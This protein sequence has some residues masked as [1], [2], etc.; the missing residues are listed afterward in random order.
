MQEILIATGNKG[1]LAEYRQI[2]AELPL[3]LLSLHDVGLADMDVDETADNFTDNAIL[4]AQ[5]YAQ[6]SGKITLADDSGLCVD[7]LDGDPGVYSARYAGP[8]ASDADRRAKLLS[9]LNDVSTAERGAQFVCVIALANPQ[10]GSV[11]TVEGVC[12]GVIA[13]V[14]GTGANGFG[15]DPVFIP[16]GHD[17]TFADL[18]VEVKHALSH[19]GRAAQALLPHLRT[20]AE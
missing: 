3:T 9:A 15:Y 2:Y 4:K 14:E 12:E 13:H 5:A 19:R 18:S 17:L 10:D 6:A 16:A 8:G 7:A 1:K 11:I 20:L